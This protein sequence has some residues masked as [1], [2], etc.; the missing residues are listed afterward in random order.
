MAPESH[1]E[2]PGTESREENRTESREENRAESREE[3]R[4]ERRFT[5]GQL[6]EK[7]LDLQHRPVIGVTSLHGEYSATKACA[8]SPRHPIIFI[9]WW[10]AFKTDVK[11]RNKRT[12]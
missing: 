3:N 2:S 1:K 4:A 5:C 10:L 11:K 12:A 8:C 6:Y 9:I 7:Q